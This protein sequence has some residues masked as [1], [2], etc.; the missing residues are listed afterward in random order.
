MGRYDY[1]YVRPG[2]R[3]TAAWQNSVVDALNELAG[4]AFNPLVKM[5]ALRLEPTPGTRGAYG[6]PASAAPPESRGWVVVMAKVLWSGGFSPNE[7][8][9]VKISVTFS[10]GAAAEVEKSSTS[11][12][13]V[14]LSFGEV[15]LMWRDGAVVKKIEVSSASNMSTTRVGTAVTIY[16]VEA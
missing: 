5:R 15:A 3:I 16:C 1:L 9:R 13:E 4:V 14:W 2:M 7:E 6:A 11:L 12:G 10:D 8:V